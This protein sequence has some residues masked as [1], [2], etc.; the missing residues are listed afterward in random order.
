MAEKVQI[1]ID[2]EFI[3]E[4]KALIEKGTYS[5]PEE[6]LRLLLKT[7]L[8]VLEIKEQISEDLKK[9]RAGK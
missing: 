4:V 6:A 3:E 2:V 1:D 5:N 8:K 7:G 9:Q